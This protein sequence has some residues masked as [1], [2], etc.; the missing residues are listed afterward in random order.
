MSANLPSNKLL[1]LIYPMTERYLRQYT[2]AGNLAVEAGCGPGQYRYAVNGDYIGFDISAN[3]Y[4]PGM[5]RNLEL[6]ADARAMPFKRNSIDLL[7][8]SN[9][10]HYFKEAAE[11]AKYVSGILTESGRFLIFDYSKKTL[12][13]LNSA[14]ERGEQGF[15]A[16][17]YSSD[18][19]EQLLEDNGFKEIKI[20]VSSPAWKRTAFSLLS[21]VSRA[22]AYAWLDRQAA[23]IVVSGKKRV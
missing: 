2:H 18:S 1:A 7:F 17:E 13:N 12:H 10:F 3:D 19:W 15:N 4:K 16:V 11:V 22:L 8:F 23:A 6:V 9:T 14:Y 21:F 20:E 5:P